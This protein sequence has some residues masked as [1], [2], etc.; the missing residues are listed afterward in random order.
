MSDLAGLPVWALGLFASAALI[1]GVLILWLPFALMGMRSRMRALRAE[2]ADMRSELRGF[3]LRLAALGVPETALS[4]AGGAQRS[5]PQEASTAWPRSSSDLDDEELMAATVL[6][7]DFPS[8]E[9]TPQVPDPESLPRRAGGLA[10]HR[11]DDVARS[12]ERVWSRAPW[13]A[14]GHAD[15]ADSREN[16]RPITAGVRIE[17]MEPPSTRRDEEEFRPRSEPKLRWPPRE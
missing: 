9:D 4:E 5:L 1:C 13:E 10:G 8:Y 15:R 3:S 16:R 6:R 14:R 12:P 7:Q 11:S 17:R 2:I